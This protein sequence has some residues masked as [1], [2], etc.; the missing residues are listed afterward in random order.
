MF[1]CDGCKR[2]GSD[3][4]VAPLVLGGHGFAAPQERIAAE[5]RNDEHGLL[6]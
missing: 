1:H 4:H 2:L 5:C 6:S 3:A